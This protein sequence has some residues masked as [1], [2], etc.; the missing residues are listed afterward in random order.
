MS[1]AS[2]HSF[3]F[4]DRGNCTLI[5]LPIT[6]SAY[7]VGV[8]MSQKEIRGCCERVMGAGRSE[9]IKISYALRNISPVA[10]T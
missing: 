9:T 4:L 7:N 6:Y 2:P 1:G 8:M 3:D 5:H 10:Q